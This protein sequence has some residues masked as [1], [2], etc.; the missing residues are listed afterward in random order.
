MT[1]EKNNLHEQIDRLIHIVEQ[2]R[3]PDGCPWDRVQT[4]QSIASC[5]L[6]ESAELIEA[7]ETSNDTGMIEELGDLLLQIIF[8]AQL[9]QERSSFTLTDIVTTINN[10]LIRRHPH[11]FGKVN[12]NGD[13]DKLIEQWEQIKRME[14]SGTDQERKSALDGIAPSMPAL[15]KAQK[16]FKKASKAKLLLP[17]ELPQ[18][19]TQESH[20]SPD[21]ITPE[22]FFCNSGKRDGMEPEKTWIPP[23]PEIAFPFYGYTRHDHL[24]GAAVLYPRLRVQL[25]G[26]GLGVVHAAGHAVIVLMRF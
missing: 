20:I 2:L 23:S 10:K 17:E 16:L 1:I 19:S 13:I 6:E 9:A 18:H 15:M 8:H 25:V 22:E 5:L 12:L 3:A 11:V 26:M 14:K 7:I 24:R 4:H 21:N